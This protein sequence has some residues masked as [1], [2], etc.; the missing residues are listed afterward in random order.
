VD[1]PWKFAGYSADIVRI[2]RDLP[3]YS[4]IRGWCLT[5]MTGFPIPESRQRFCVIDRFQLAHGSANCK[6]LNK[7]SETDGE[8]EQVGSGINGRL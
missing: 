4:L 2:L 6:A 3:A 8:T 5:K 1:I 7:R